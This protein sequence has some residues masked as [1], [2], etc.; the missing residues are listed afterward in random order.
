MERPRNKHRRHLL[1]PACLAVGVV[2]RPSRLEGQLRRFFDEIIGQLT[3]REQVLGILDCDRHGRGATDADPRRTHDR[4]I[5]GETRP[6]AEDGE[7]EGS[8]AT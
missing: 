6:H 5:E 3:A 4:V 7:I 1:A 8:A 2:H